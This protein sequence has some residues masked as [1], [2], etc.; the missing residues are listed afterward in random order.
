M[1]VEKV[2]LSFKL[3]P[4]VTCKYTLGKSVVFCEFCFWGSMFSPWTTSILLTFPLCPHTPFILFYYLHSLIGFPSWLS[5]ANRNGMPF[6][7][8][9]RSLQQQCL[10]LLLFCE[11][12]YI[13]N[14]VSFPPFY[15]YNQHSVKHSPVHKLSLIFEIIY[16][17]FTSTSSLL[18]TLVIFDRD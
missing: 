8:L 12:A 18:L 11:D 17:L 10:H 6:P 4:F 5:M 1:T 7:L 16:P 3:C 14:K 15:V 13:A 9:L 2:N